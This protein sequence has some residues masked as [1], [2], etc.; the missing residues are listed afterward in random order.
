VT[1]E[2]QN[3]KRTTILAIIALIVL[4]AAGVYYWRYYHPAPQGAFSRSGQPPSLVSML[5]PEAPYVIYADVAALRNSAFLARLIALVPAPAED[6]EYTEFVRASGF[7]YSRDL[8]RVAI[9]VVPSSPRPMVWTIAEGRFDQQKI[10]AYALRTGAAEQHNGQTVYVMPASTPGDK[11]AMSFL[12]PNR[13][14][15][16]TGPSTAAFATAPTA[17]E[18]T[19]AERL[20]RVSGSML[21]AIARTDSIPKNLVIGTVRIDQIMSSLKGVQ[22]LTLAAQPEKENL[23]VMLEGECDSPSDARS[24]DLALSGFRLVGRPL[25]ADPSIKKQLTPQGAE[26]LSQ[27]IGIVEISH[28]DRRVRLSVAF[29]PEMLN[30]LAAPAPPQKRS[31]ARSGN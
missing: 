17:S 24:L 10:T 19:T 13:I 5:P 20:A 23:R 28:D 30:G 3:L 8:D 12:A 27:L 21:F 9:A 16:V 7:D 11:V 15:L 2:S 14:R 29:T 4:A 22:W 1:G 25:L 26:A 6:P 18:T 31:P